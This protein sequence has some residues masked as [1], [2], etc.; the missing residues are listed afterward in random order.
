[1]A[2]NIILSNAGDLRTTQFSFSTVYDIGEV[3]F[4]I[5]TAKANSNQVFLVL[6]NGRNLREIVELIRSKNETQKSVNALYKLNIN[7]SIRVGDEAVEIYLLLI[8]KET[9]EYS[10]SS[11]L[12]INLS[13]ENYKIARQ[14][15]IV[16][17]VSQKV[18]EYYTKILV[19]TEINQEL[20]KKIEEELHNESN[21]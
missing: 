4:Y 9:D 18:Q 6:K 19:L 10:T 14:A 3:N 16:E 13:A 5:P 15:K 17:E 21:L 2:C 12:K 20:Y 8:N 11:K 1:M 7:S